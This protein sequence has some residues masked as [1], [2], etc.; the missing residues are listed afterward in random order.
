MN[1]FL[2]KEELATVAAM[3][4]INKL[5]ADNPYVIEQIIDESI[6]L[7]SSYLAR[8]YDTD[9]IFSATGNSRHLTV[10]KYLK[11]IVIFE[12]YDRLTREENEVAHRRYETA[13]AWL[14]DLNTGTLADPSLPPTPVEPGT[15]AASGDV[16]FGSNTQYQSRY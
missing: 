13:M 10:L 14:A 15:D 12:I 1:S 16:R 6:S 9:A 2:S 7:M 4:T 3:P 5:T 11:D 8:H